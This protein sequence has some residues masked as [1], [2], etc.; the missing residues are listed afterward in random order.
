[1][2]LISYGCGCLF[3]S[4]AFTPK[5]RYSSSIPI[6]SALLQQG[7]VWYWNADLQWILPVKQVGCVKFASARLWFS[8]ARSSHEDAVWHQCQCQ[9]TEISRVITITC[10]VLQAPQNRQESHKSTDKVLI[11]WKEI[12]LECFTLGASQYIYAL[13]ST[14]ED[15]FKRQ[16]CE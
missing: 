7:I 11:T 14:S 15:D 6:N 12:T 1:M 10:S 9:S 8:I 13:S 16:I 2:R 4:M 5:S 3:C